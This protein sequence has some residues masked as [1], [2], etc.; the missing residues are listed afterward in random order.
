[1]KTKTI[2]P[3]PFVA[4]FIHTFNRFAAGKNA[5]NDLEKAMFKKFKPVAPEA[6]VLMKQA[7]KTFKALPVKQKGKTAAAMVKEIDKPVSASAVAVAFVEEIKKYINTEILD[8]KNPDLKEQPGKVRLLQYKPGGDDVYPNQVHIFKINDIRTNDYMPRLASGDFRPGELQRSCIARTIGDTV[9][10]DCSIMQAP[11]DGYQNG[12]VCLRVLQVTA[13]S[14]LTLTGVNFFDTDAKIWM[15]KKGTTGRYTKIN[16]FVYGDITTPVYKTVNGKRK[17][18]ADKRV[19]DKIYFSIPAAL[20]PDI[21]EFQVA[22][23]N[24]SGITGPGID[25]EILFSNPQYIEV[26]P[27]I[28]AKFQIASERL[29]AIDETG[30]TEFWHDNVGIKINAVPFFRDLT[31]GN[32]QQHSFRFDGVDT[33][34]TRAM[35]SVLFSHTRPIGGVIL[36]VMGYEID[37]EDA[38]KN[39]IMEW[40]DIFWDLLKEQWKLINGNKEAMAALNKIA[41]AGFYGY[42]A[43]GCAA[44]L[45]AAIDFVVSLWLSPDLIIQDVLSYSVNDLGRMTNI[46]IPMEQADPGTNLYTTPGGIDVRLMLNQKITN[47]YTEERGYLSD[48]DSFY[49]IRYRFNR[50][51]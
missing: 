29:S 10:W 19:N 20:A 36:S 43:I 7:A 16:A 42:V 48:D 3:G 6:A 24:S 26:I 21:Y 12:D 11:C 32:L 2:T 37:G 28:N 22:V 23:P 47:Q 17:L 34:E 27:P 4:S 13:G 15:R 18:I 39:H 31:L 45:T 9:T 40:T 46:N 50:L 41:G 14:S 25:E 35:E 44:L 5:G 38:Y 30:S 1:M 49:N 33:R 51:S 8:T